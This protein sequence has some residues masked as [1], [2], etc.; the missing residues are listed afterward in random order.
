MIHDLSD[1]NCWGRAI[2]PV[3]GEK[4]EGS[5]LRVTG[6][7]TPLPKPEDTVIA[8]NGSKW[9]VVDVD[10]MRNPRDGFRATLKVMA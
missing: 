4:Q 3:W 6:C 9:V 8:N 10:Y 1:G 2:Y 5:T 7:L